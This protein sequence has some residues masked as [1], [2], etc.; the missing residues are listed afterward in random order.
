MA[1]SLEKIAYYNLRS[2]IFTGELVPGSQLSETALTKEIGVSRTPV[3]HAL[4]QLETQGLVVQVPRVGAFVRVPNDRE[5]DEIFH[6]REVLECEAAALAAQNANTDQIE[7]IVRYE[8]EYRAVAAEMRAQGPGAT[9]SEMGMRALKADLQFHWMILR[10]SG[11]RAI[12]RVVIDSM[13]QTRTRKFDVQAGAGWEGLIRKLTLISREHLR[14][15]VAIRRRDAQTARDAMAAHIRQAKVNYL[16]LL[17][18]HEREGVGADWSPAVK[19]LV[20]QIER[21]RADE[22]NET[23]FLSVLTGAN[24]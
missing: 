22:L 13:L 18:A 3:R 23:D 24:N 21:D 4:R 8:R 7:A 11:N 12:T 15:S 5:T 10:A 17:D 1:V 6:L 19:L 14:V 20:G 2:R 16:A 9:S